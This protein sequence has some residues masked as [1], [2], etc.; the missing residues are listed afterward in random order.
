V[1]AKQAEPDPSE[2]DDLMVAIRR[3]RLADEAY[4]ATKADL[5]DARAELVAAFKAVGVEGFSL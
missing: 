1:P 4:K 2:Y 5:D 3:W